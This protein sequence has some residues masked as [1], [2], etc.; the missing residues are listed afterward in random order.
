M[1]AVKWEAFSLAK[2]CSKLAVYDK[3]PVFIIL[4]QNALSRLP[5]AIE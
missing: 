2:E 5:Q 3:M 4:F 1:A